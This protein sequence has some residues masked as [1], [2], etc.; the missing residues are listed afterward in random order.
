MAPGY[1]RIRSDLIAVRL[2]WSDDGDQH[3]Y[4]KIEIPLRHNN[5][6]A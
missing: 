2:E 6:S 3:L 1:V 5:L 4:A